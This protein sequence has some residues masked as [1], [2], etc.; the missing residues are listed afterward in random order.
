M[1]NRHIRNVA[2][3]TAGRLLRRV[4]AVLPACFDGW[5]LLHG[6]PDAGASRRLQAPPR[7]RPATRALPTAIR[8]SGKAAH[9][10]SMPSTAP[11]SRS[12]RTPSTGTRPRPA[13]SPSP[14]SRR[15]KAATASTTC[16][17]SIGARPGRRACRAPPIISTISAVPRPSRPAGSS[18]MC[19]R[20][21][22]RCRR[23]STWSGTR[24]RRPASF[25]PSRPPCAARCASSCPS[26]KSTTARSRSST[27][28]SISSTTTA[29][30]SFKGY[31]YWLRS[32]AGHPDDKYSGH[33]FTFWQYT[34]TGVIPGIRGDADINVFNGD[35]RAWKK[36]LK[37]NAA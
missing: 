2:N 26:S 4:A 30:P 21:R 11:T 5:L 17:T 32:V 13:A 25:G 28:R 15:P 20:K 29:C 7:L 9:R 33:P 35:M 27:P 36:W 23:F 1:L 8:T 16:S 22:A 19:R 12:T 31:P 24:S 18:T 10:G 6:Q 14:S 3:R 37:A 34:G